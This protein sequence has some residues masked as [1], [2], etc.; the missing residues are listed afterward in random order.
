M[1]RFCPAPELIRQAPAFHCKYLEQQISTVPKD[2]A[3]EPTLD[4][5]E[6]NAKFNR[7]RLAPF[8]KNDYARY[9]SA[10][11]PVAGL[12]LAQKAAE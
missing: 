9:P 10:Q 2:Q 3:D 6:R 4:P 1:V 12:R 11:I 7:T 5:E 8:F